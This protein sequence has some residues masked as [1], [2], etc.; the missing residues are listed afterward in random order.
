MTDGCVVIEISV[1]IWWSMNDENL[2]PLNLRTKKEQRIIT[3]KGGSVI[4]FKKKYAAKIREMKKKAKLT[5]QDLTWFE[6]TMI[7]PEASGVDMG[8][9]LILLR[10][11][12]EPKDYI[13]LKQDQHKL[14]FGDKSAT[15]V[16]VQINN[17][18]TNEER[19]KL[20]NRLINTK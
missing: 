2:I 13:K 6:Q 14:R 19:D 1:S 5:G 10:D 4:S 18:M 17:I 11:K 12:L 9:D 7:S 3:S 8:A 15:Q 20:I 16:N